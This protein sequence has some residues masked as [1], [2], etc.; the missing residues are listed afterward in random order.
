MPCQ[1]GRKDV[2]TP[3]IG[4]AA[5]YPDVHRHHQKRLRVYSLTPGGVGPIIDRLFV[6]CT[7]RPEAGRK[8]MVVLGA[9]GGV[10][11]CVR[12]SAGS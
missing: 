7:T 2:K 3:K 11:S 8:M 12:S 5:P 1:G 4:S 10:E 6:I 9:F